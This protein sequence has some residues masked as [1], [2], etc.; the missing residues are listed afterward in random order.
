M[1][2]G[3]DPGADI[4][5]S[6]DEAK[7]PVEGAYTNRIALPSSSLATSVGPSFRFSVKYSRALPNGLPRFGV[8]TVIN[9]NRGVIQ[10]P[11]WRNARAAR[12]PRLCPIKTMAAGCS[13]D[14]IWVTTSLTL[15]PSASKSDPSPLSQVNASKTGSAALENPTLKQLDEPG[16]RDCSGHSVAQPEGNNAWPSDEVTQSFHTS[17]AEFIP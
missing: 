7:Y 10:V 15:L 17:G 1:D 9:P 14:S 8:P 11:D 16:G 5:T 3:G 13:T 6:N 2:G 4:V 12:P